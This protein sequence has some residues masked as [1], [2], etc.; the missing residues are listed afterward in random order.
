MPNLVYPIMAVMMI[1]LLSDVIG[2]DYRQN[3]KTANE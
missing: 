1:G 2:S 3:K